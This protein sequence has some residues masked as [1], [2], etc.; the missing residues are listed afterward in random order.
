MV[1][2]KALFL[3]RDGVINASILHDGKP[4]PPR[5]IEEFVYLPRVEE[6][7]LASRDKGYV[8]VIVTNQPDIASGKTSRKLVQHFHKRIR[9]ELAIDKI[10]MCTHVEADGCKCRKPGIKMIEDAARNFPIIL[11]KSAIVG[12]RWRDIECGQNA[13]LGR[14]FFVDYSYEECGPKPPFE[15]VVDLF[16][17]VKLL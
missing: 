4:I 1:A 11:S 12:D 15:T 2:D 5:T 6:A 7:L 16:E 3:D 14:C 17:A 9:D 8:N 13:N 10:Y